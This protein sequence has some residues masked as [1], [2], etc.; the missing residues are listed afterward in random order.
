MTVH[1]TPTSFSITDSAV[2]DLWIKEHKFRDE[3][4]IDSHT[5]TRLRC[6]VKV[7]DNSPLLMTRARC[8]TDT[9]K[10]LNYVHFGGLVTDDVS[11]IVIIY[12]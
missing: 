7:V 3:A 8:P 12:N 6:E 11:F 9:S 2:R 4:E 1:E 10:L 5:G